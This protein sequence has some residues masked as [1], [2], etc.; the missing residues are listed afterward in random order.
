MVDRFSN[1]PYPIFTYVGKYKKGGSKE[2][3][4]LCA[5]MLIACVSVFAVSDARKIEFVRSN[6]PMMSDFEKIVTYNEM[7]KSATGGFVLNTLIGCGIGSYTQ[8]DWVG[9]TIGLCG[10]V[11]G[12][13]LVGIGIPFIM[14]GSEPVAPH[15]DP[16]DPYNPYPPM[17]NDS[18]YAEQDSRDTQMIVGYTLVGIGSAV[19]AG[20]KIYEMI[21]PFQYANRFNKQLKDAFGM[22]QLAVVPTYTRDSQWGTTVAA[23]FAF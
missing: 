23:S 7:H 8:G 9:G 5:V 17:S 13:L 16:Y 20:F 21:R 18:H 2:I 1:V 14:Y 22:T 4:M 11:G 3:V 12:A 15:Y 19:W 10:E 6:S